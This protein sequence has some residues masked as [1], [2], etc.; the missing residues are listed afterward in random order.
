MS[1]KQHKHAFAVKAWAEGWPIRVQKEPGGF[2]YLDLSPEWKCDYKYVVQ[3]ALVEFRKAEKEGK[4]VQRLGFVD[5]ALVWVDVDMNE[6]EL[7]ENKNLI[8]LFRIK[9]EIRFN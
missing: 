8:S 5:A 3:D 6:I 9:P 1:R 4:Q 7:T 2:W